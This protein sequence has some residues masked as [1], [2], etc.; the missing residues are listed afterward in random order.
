MK[1]II[2]GKVLDSSKAEKIIEFESSLNKISLMK[3]KAGQFFT[4]E[5]GM[6]EPSIS[7]LSAEKTLNFLDV[8]ANDIP[9]KKYGEILRKHF[10]IKPAPE[11]PLPKSA[12]LVA[13]AL[14]ENLYRTN[15]GGIFYTECLGEVKELSPTE[16]LKWVELNQDEIPPEKLDKILKNHFPT[17][18][19]I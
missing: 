8:H 6:L 18:G 16:A 9:G 19:I 13:A 17:I 4:I 7:L 14:F 2:N 1:K 3:T 15:P 5:P 10:N 11:N 12:L